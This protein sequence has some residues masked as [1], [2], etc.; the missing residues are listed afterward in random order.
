MC[1]IAVLRFSNLRGRNV[2][3]LR[4]EGALGNT[5]PGSCSRDLPKHPRVHRP[6]RPV[7][8]GMLRQL[9]QRTVPGQSISES[10]S[11]S[12]DPICSSQKPRL[13]F[14]LGHNR[15]VLMGSGSHCGVLAGEEDQAGTIEEKPE[16][17]RPSRNNLG[18]KSERYFATLRQSISNSGQRPTTLTV[19]WKPPETFLSLQLP[20]RPPGNLR[21]P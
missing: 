15:H 4:L 5:R 1:K 20:W 10:P 13:P 17:P 8:E 12:N 19:A 16:Q 7:C 2:E 9:L 3:F 11:Q 14:L 6:A 21:K 18:P